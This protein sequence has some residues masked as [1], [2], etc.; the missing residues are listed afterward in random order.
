MSRRLGWGIGDQALSSITNFALGILVARSVSLRE[1]GAFSLAFVVYTFAI[2]ASRAVAT[3]PLVVRYSATH[4]DRWRSG[5]SLA[6]G[7]ALWMGLVFGIGCVV[8]GV[9]VGGPPRPA[10]VTLG[11]MLPGLLLQDSWRFAFFA[12]GRGNRAFMNDLV[13][14]LVLFPLLAVILASGSV[15]VIELMLAWGGAACVAGLFGVVQARVLPRPFGARKWFR[16]QGD[17][18]PR[19]LGE[20]ILINGAAQLWVF[21]VGAVAG[22]ATVGSLR[23]GLI[24]LGPL[25]VVFMGFGMMAIPE[26]VRLLADDPSRLR[27]GAAMLSVTLAT[28]ALA[29]GGLIMLVPT[30]LGVALLG[31]AWIPARRLVIPL[32]LVFVG[33]GIQKGADVGLRALAAARRSLRTRSA[34]AVLTVTGVMVGVVVAGAKGA[35]WGLAAAYLLEGGLWWWQFAVGL[36]DH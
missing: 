2:G 3:E 21:G 30:R 1:F 29:W 12:Q 13:W 20:A 14:L 6:C 11:A 15:S 7:A 22:L 4:R 33:S 18:A 16:E 9:V 27:R 19:F 8:V 10:L 17:L 34:E 26:G 23:A 32:M 35:A 24:L 28:T 36:R 25:N 31:S 5:T